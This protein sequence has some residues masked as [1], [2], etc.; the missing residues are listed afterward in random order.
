VAATDPATGDRA[1]AGR[2][3]RVFP[4]K[5]HKP[6]AIPDVKGRTLSEAQQ[7][8]NNAGFTTAN[9]TQ[10]SQDVPRDQVIG[11][12]PGGGELAQ[13]GPGSSPIIILVSNGITVPDVTGKTPD[14]AQQILESAGFSVQVN[15]QDAQN[16]EPRNTVISQNPPAG[17]PA[18]KGDTVT[19][20]ATKKD[21]GFNLGPFHFGNC[22]NGNGQDQNNDQLPVPNVVGETFEQAKQTLRDAGFK[23]KGQRNITGHVI[24][25]DPLGG[26]AP[27]GS[28]VQLF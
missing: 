27:R 4:S 9:K 13:P 8:L 25:Q 22:D 6:I 1:E 17:Q 5:G 3:V 20:T 2:V 10:S 15:Q 7:I 14:Q 26:N 28:E 16:G 24:S 21:C 18:N 12:R 19:L 11:T 23:P